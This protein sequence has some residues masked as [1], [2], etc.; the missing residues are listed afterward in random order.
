MGRFFR[1]Q[2]II[3]RT[4][5]WPAPKHQPVIFCL[6]PSEQR[7]DTKGRKMSASHEITALLA[8][9][10][11]GDQQALDDLT[12]RLYKKLRQLAN[13]YLRK[14]R[15]DHSLQPTAIV[16]EAYIR[17]LSQKQ[18]PFCENRSQFFAV[19]ARLM[20]QILVDHARRRRTRKRDAR[21]VPFDDTIDLPEERKADLLALDAALGALEQVDARKCKAIEMRY[22]G[23]LSIDEIAE[24]LN[25]STKTVRRDLTFAEAWLHRRITGDGNRE[26]RTLG[27][28]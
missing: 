19:A 13:S 28:S 6:A 3:S 15:P 7:N 23:G 14:E 10:A 18:T 4:H 1:E 8:Q 24:V 12:Q 16:N 9:W 17:L 26:S 2:D 22:F 11:S 5:W 20:R 25:L 21:N 27:A